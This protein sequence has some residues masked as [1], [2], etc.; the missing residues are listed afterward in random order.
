MCPETPA[1]IGPVVKYLLAL[2]TTHCRLERVMRNELRLPIQQPKASDPTPTEPGFDDRFALALREFGPIGLFALLVILLAGH[3]IGAMLV[4]AWVWRSHTP[5]RDLGFVRPRRWTRT[6][7][8]GLLAGVVFKLFM[9]AVLMPLLGADPNNSA[10][11]DLVRNGAALPG[12]LFTVVIGGGLGEEII[13]RGYLFERLGRLFGPGTGAK[14]AVLLVSALL[15]GL[16]HYPDQGIAGATQA[17][18]TG[19]VFGGL[20]MTTGRLWLPIVMHA[21]FDVTAVLIIYWD[22]EWRVAHWI[23]R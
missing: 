23:F 3:W 18:M 13:W 1:R 4:L 10:Y 9:K 15:F 8:A 16:A 22:L 20:L 2:D 12:M 5:W 6:V 7:V 11:H 21:A 19:A 17:V 14:L